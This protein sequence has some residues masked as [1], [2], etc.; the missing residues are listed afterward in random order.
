M[1]NIGLTVKEIDV[2][3]PFNFVID[4]HASIVHVGPTLGRLLPSIL[5]VSFD[6][7]FSI[8]VPDI[9]AN[10]EEISSHGSRLFRLHVHQLDKLILKG[11]MLHLAQEQ[12]VL[13]VGSPWY[14]SN[15]DIFSLGLRLND[16][17]I[18]DSV[19]DFVLQTYSLNKSLDDAQALA[20]R[21]ETLN[22]QLETRVAE[23][24]QEVVTANDALL[25]A[26]EELR[27]E[28]A[29]RELAEERIR[30]LAHHDALTGLANRHMLHALLNQTLAVHRRD[31]GKLALLFIDLDHF[32]PIND[33]HGH[34]VGDKLL[35]AVA[36]RLSSLVREID[37]VSRLGGD[38]FVVVLENVSDNESITKIVKKITSSLAAPYIVDSLQLETTSSIGISLFPE[39]G[40]DGDSLIRNADSA[41]YLAK[42]NGR[43][44]FHYFEP[45]LSEPGLSLIG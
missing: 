14:T 1:S 32:K 2:I 15:T 8:G 29:E 24:T 30:Y 44:S 33:S 5:G 20:G 3:F 31:N 43:N 16:F 38:E 34:H 27:H 40:D 45:E 37:I 39:D 21:L 28:M 10:Y 17:A 41:M 22:Q 35:I 42:S 26:N 23:R 9:S 13:F 25:A 4:A 18:H 6:D 19:P 11:Q 7:V 12:Q 36:E